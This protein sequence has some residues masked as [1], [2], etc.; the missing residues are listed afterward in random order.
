MTKPFGHFSADDK[1]YIITE[2]FAPPRAQINFL[3]NDTVISG[4]N[5]FGGGDGVFNNQTLMYNHPQG[6][7]RLVRDGR[8]YFYLRDMASGEYWSSGLLPAN[9][10]GAKLT[11]HVG[12]GYSKFI[13][14]YKNIRCESRVF[15][16]PD[17]PVEIWEFVLTNSSNES[18]TLWLAPYVEWLLGG[19]ATFSSPYSYLRSSYDPAL[20]AVSSYNTS[21]ERPHDRYNAF[22][23]TDGKVTQW[24]GGRRDFLGPFGSPASPRAIEDGRMSC[25]ESWCEELAGALAIEVLLTA[26]AS[27]TITVL[28]GSFNTE[29]EKARLIQKVLPA[30]YRAAAWEKLIGEKQSMLE[31]VWI[32]T[33]D[34]AINRLV[35]IWA[36][37]QI[38]LCVEFGRDGARGFRD[39]LQDAWGIAP[40]NSPLARAKIIETLRHQHSDGHAVR[41]WL[42]LQPHHYSDGPAWIAP[43]IAAYL[44]ETGDVSLLA[45]KVPYLDKGEA[46]VLEHMLLGVRHLSTDLGAHGLVLAHEGDWND[47]LNWMGRGGKGESVWTSMALYY[48]L[49]VI[50]EMATEL[51]N[52]PSLAV[53][54]QERAGKILAAIEQHGWDGNWYLAG[55]SDFGNPVGSHA[56]R[57]GKIFLNTQTWASLTGIA[58]GERL[59]KCW[60]AVDELL[61]SEHGSLT[62]TPHYT[63]KDENVGRVTMLLPG[64]YENGTPYC[65]G[66][67]FKIVADIE[68]GRAD[69]GLASWYKVMPDN[70]QHPS[71]VSGCEPYAFTNQYLGPA[72]GRAGDSISGWITG[73]AGWM[74]RAVLEYFCGIQ[75]GYKGLIIKPCLPSG[76]NQIKVTRQLRGKEYA[77][78]VKR[79]ANGYVITVNGKPYRD[80]G[81]A[82]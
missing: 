18:K 6:R 40:F 66:T 24:C 31:K 9:R 63:A 43:T 17:E 76:W 4:V 59:Q 1:E 34:P 52:D 55:W 68:A 49:N 57:E 79:D 42:P 67:A 78:E 60:R 82:Y 77:I 48:S 22:V 11:T 45:E 35:N 81:L 51:L 56:N 41:G 64:M 58:K 69:K 73:S 50:A 29:E 16:A 30:D 14:E 8:R 75:P 38:Q 47:S 19:Y 13:T 23:A 7:V 12:L 15:L 54:M 20:K 62:L 80:G 53:E 61:E 28:L 21:D 32:E 46:T 36:K 74:F 33:P 10:D 70:P 3:W 65:H 25:A 72:N 39:T 37:Q 26:G 5:Q 27:K 71:S 2:P 44:K